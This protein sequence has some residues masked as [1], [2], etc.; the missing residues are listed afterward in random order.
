M[1][2]EEA[3]EHDDAREAL[4]K[5]ELACSRNGPGT[6]RMFLG[7]WCSECHKFGGVGEHFDHCPLTILRA[8][9][10][11]HEAQKCDDGHRLDRSH[12]CI[13]CGEQVYTPPAAPDTESRE[14]EPPASQRSTPN[15]FAGQAQMG[16]A[17][18]GAEFMLLDGEL[19]LYSTIGFTPASSK[20]DG[21]LEFIHP[22]VEGFPEVDFGKVQ[23]VKPGAG[24]VIVALA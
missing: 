16:T 20:G 11:R 22:E 9:V 15:M 12:R 23:F 5:I 2:P 24:A 19:R 3:I 4:E 18:P 17:P 13:T 8:L 10:E 6:T 7:V 21:W 1:T 14:V